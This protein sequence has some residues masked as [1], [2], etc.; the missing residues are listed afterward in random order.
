VGPRINLLI[1]RA[2]AGECELIAKGAVAGEQR[3]FLRLASGSFRSD[4]TSEPL[5]SDP[6]LRANATVAG[7]ELTYTCVPPGSGQRSGVDRDDDG[8]P[9]RDELDAGS[10]PAD[11][12]SIPSGAS[13]TTT[14]SA[15]ST[16][17]TTTV[18][19][20]PP[21]PSK[22]SARKIGLAAKNASAKAKCYAKAVSKGILFDPLCPQRADLA[23][24]TAY[25]K[26]EVLPNDCLTSGDASFIEFI[27]DSG[28]GVLNSILVPTSVRSHCTGRKLTLAGKK[29]RARAKC[30]AKAVSKGILVDGDCLTRAHDRLHQGWVK[31]ELAGGE[32]QTLGDEP[33]IQN[34]VDAFLAFVIDAL[35]P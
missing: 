22:C 2:A 5:L 30:Q 29:A 34:G 20:P 11:P 15:T 19:L 26:V 4:R 14:T 1:A 3:G 9:D 17:S 35:E 10:D 27:N 24:E 13:T 23:L 6:A 16:T 28:I 7:Q 8:F 33:I 21:G 25:A 31:V 32:C 12:L 18:T